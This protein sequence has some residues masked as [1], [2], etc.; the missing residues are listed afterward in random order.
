EEASGAWIVSQGA[1]GS[2]VI[3]TNFAPASAA[4]QIDETLRRVGQCTDTIDWMVWS[5]DQPA[6]LGELLAKAGAA[7]REWMLY[8]KIGGEP[9]TWLVIDLE[10]LAE[11]VPVADDFHVEQVRDAEQF[12][13]WVDINA[14]GFGSTD[15]SA[16]RAAYLRHG[17]GDNAQAIHFVGYLLDQPVTSSTLLIAG[18]NASAYNISTPMELRGQGYGSAVTHATLLAA[19]QQGFS[20]SWIWSSLLG[21]SVYQKLGFVI[22]DFGIREYQ[23]KKRG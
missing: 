14:R 19:R 21:K 1:P 9:G 23:W 17:F 11:R 10:S 4:E 7:S 8:G 2:Q 18:G 6:N 3:K 15:Y 20:H 5:D 13:V 12:E 16:F 22:T